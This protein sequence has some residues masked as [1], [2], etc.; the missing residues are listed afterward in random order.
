MSLNLYFVRLLFM[1]INVIFLWIIASVI[2]S[3]D[4][5]MVKITIN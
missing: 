1:S 5:N 3:F 2:W 4:T